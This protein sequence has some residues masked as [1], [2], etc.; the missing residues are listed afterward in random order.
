MS[1]S[2]YNLIQFAKERGISE[3]TVNKLV[4]GNQTLIKLLIA[5]IAKYHKDPVFL[6]KISA[7]KLETMNYAASQA[8]ANG[9]I[10]RA[11]KIL[12][13]L[14]TLTKEN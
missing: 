13:F 4:G 8:Y 2:P 10:K 3:D 12:K 6:D 11:E 1:K 9:Q 14:N 5:Y 7:L